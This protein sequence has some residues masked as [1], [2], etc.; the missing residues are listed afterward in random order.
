MVW[1]DLAHAYGSIPHQ[2][3]QVAMHQDYIP[4][5]LSNLI[6]SI[7]T[8]V[9]SQAADSQPPG[10]G[11]QRNASY[12]HSDTLQMRRQVVQARGQDRNGL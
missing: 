3:I 1:L 9:R 10:I 8:A 11:L 5:H 6:T 12:S 7:T 2:L 4:D